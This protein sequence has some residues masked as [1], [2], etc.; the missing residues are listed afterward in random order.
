M[1][2][3]PSVDGFVVALPYRPRT[4]WVRNV[5]AAGSATVDHEGQAVRVDRPELLAGAEADALLLRT[6]RRTRRLYGVTDVLRL[7]WAEAPAA[8]GGATDGRAAGAPSATGGVV[9][10]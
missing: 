9:R 8:A 6:G 2:A 4:D 7:R 1:I 10:G 5:I 3:V